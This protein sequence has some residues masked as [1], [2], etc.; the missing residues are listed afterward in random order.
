[1]A[2]QPPATTD[3]A[4]AFSAFYYQAFDSNRNQLLSLY[5]DLSTLSWEGEQFIGANNI[6]AKLVGL[7]FQRV[8]HKVATVDA[9]PANPSAPTLIVLVTGQL[10]IDDETNPQHFSETFQLVQEGTNFWIYNSIFRLNYG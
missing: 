3:I 6:V 5:R 9:Q 7:P 8:V 2:L 4:K 1:M 10:L